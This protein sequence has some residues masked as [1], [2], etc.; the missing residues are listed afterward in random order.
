MNPEG[1]VDLF[2]RQTWEELEETHHSDTGRFQRAYRRLDLEKE[3]GVRLGCT[4][5]GAVW[6]LLVEAGSSEEALRGKFPKWKG[7]DF[8]ILSLDTPREGN[9]HIRLSLEQGENRD[10]FVTVCA[11]LVKGLDGCTTNDGRRR[12]IADFLTRWSSFFERHGLEGLSFEEQRGLYGELWWLRN[13][14]RAGTDPMTAVTSWKG[15]ERGYQDFETTG[16]AVEVKTTMM[17]EPRK[18]QINNER[19]LDSRALLSL[20]LFVLTVT[21]T[22]TAGETLPDLVQSLRDILSERPVAYAFEKSLGKAGYLDVHADLYRTAY[23][24][25]KEELFQVTEGFPRIT[26]MPQGLGDLHYTVVLSACMNFACEPAGYFR[27]IKE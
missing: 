3:T 23:S 10:I 5:P 18:V 9:R 13:M 2:I 16:H 11:D 6:E 4:S 27:L 25:T 20:H 22:P 14:A 12:E 15:C 7:M 17:K 26:D 24:F 8:E 21:K 1:R 19:Q